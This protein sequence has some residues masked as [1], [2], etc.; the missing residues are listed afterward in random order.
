MIKEALNYTMEQ[1]NEYFDYKRS[2]FIP[3]ALLPDSIRERM[4]PGQFDRL[5]KQGGGVSVAKNGAIITE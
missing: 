5:L 4:K 2:F 3:V 1:E